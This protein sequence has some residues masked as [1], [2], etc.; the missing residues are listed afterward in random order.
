MLRATRST[1]PF[2]SAGMRWAAVITLS[3]YFVSSPKIAL[4]TAL[5]MS[6]SKPSIR[7]FSGLREPSR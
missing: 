1:S 4:V 5:T 7:P 6:M 2:C 3:W